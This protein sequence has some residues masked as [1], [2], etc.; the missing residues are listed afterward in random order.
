MTTIT[1]SGI[2]TATTTAQIAAWVGGRLVG[3]GD[4]P[5]RGMQ[6][7]AESQ[8]GHL[9]Y[10]GRAV[11]QA[12]W[13]R[14]AAS[15]ALARNGLQLA[16]PAGKALI[17]VDDVDLATAVVQEQMAPPPP[18]PAIGRDATAVVD[19]TAQIDPSARIGPL[20]MIGKG[21]VIGARTVLHGLVTVMDDAR[22]G[23][24]CTLW[25]GVVIRDR[26]ELGDRCI[27]H[28][29]VTIGADGF[30]YRPSPDG[31]GLVKIPQL[32]TVRIGED[33]EI[34]AGTC[35]DRGKFG[36]TLVGSGTKIDNLCMIAH[37]CVIGRS[38]V[39]AG[40]SALAGSATVGDGTLL[41]GRA[42]ISDHIQVGRGVQIG[43][44]SIVMR[45]VPDGALVVGYP[46]IEAGLWKRL[47][48]L[49]Q[50]LPELF[51]RSGRST[52]D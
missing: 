41:G 14:C 28:P 8:P 43:I 30:G 33:V 20:C 49:L 9:T 46:A 11:L 34:G 29:N 38:V 36:A 44:G 40:C 19:P 51:R 47:S 52:S 5:I 27:L 31:R 7:L 35:I 25:P 22:V 37:N 32:G 6:T 3:P 16:V 50:R 1:S 39:M 48:V 4:L 13:E 26:C 2:P 17:F 23:A 24:D 21:A 12:D 45:D 15:A 18:L 10:V 42:T